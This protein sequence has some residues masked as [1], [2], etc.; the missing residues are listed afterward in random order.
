V[1]VTLD[2]VAFDAIRTGQPAAGGI[3]FA[4][5]PAPP[6][7]NAAQAG[8]LGGGNVVPVGLPF[9]L[10][11]DV[12]DG[13]G[14]RVPLAGAAGEAR[15]GL[16]LP[17]LPAGAPGGAGGAGAAGGQAADAHTWLYAV[18]DGTGA[19]LGYVRPA[20]GLAPVPGGF[21]LDLPAAA[22][23][24]T[25]FLP[26]V[27][28]PAYVQNFD[29]NVHIYSGPTAGAIDFGVAA[30]QFTTFTVVAPQ[31]AGRLYVN[32]PATANYGWIDAAGVGPT[33]PPG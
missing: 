20:G 10:T 32:N 7:E 12:R 14:N 9:D 26:A 31:V 3:S 11:L 28:V 22:L 13:A 27:L 5:D 2:A 33:G 29:P 6:L 1:V 16:V 19:F 4:F 21:G 30:P 17:L 25:L 8:V 18:Y 23:Q 15:V 24:G